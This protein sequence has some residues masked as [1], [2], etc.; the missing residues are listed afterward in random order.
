MSFYLPA[1]ATSV[2]PFTQRWTDAA[3]FTSVQQ[4]A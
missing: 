3:L 2:A 1:R 4:T